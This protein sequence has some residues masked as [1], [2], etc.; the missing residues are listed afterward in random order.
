MASL[1]MKNSQG[2]LKLF[3]I[4][5]YPVF[6]GF[7]EFYSDK[8]LIEKEVNRKAHLLALVNGFIIGMII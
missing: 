4:W 2:S 5:I 6:L 3:S 8:I 7:Y 1:R